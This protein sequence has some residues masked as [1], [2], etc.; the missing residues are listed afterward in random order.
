MAMQTDVFCGHIHQSGYIVQQ[1]GSRVKSI[2]VRGGASAAQFD[3]FSTLTAPVTATYAQS[4]SAVTVTK[5]AHGLVSGQVIGISYQ[6]GTGG[7]ATSGNYAVTVV[8]ADTFTVVSPN[9]NSVTAGAVCD[10]V[11]DGTWLMSLDL[12]AGDTYQNYLLLPGEGL[13][14]TKKVYALMSNLYSATVFYG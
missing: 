13:R 4:G 2:S 8:T 14:A 6:P 12:V 10:Y 11:V 9:P 7:A 3:L 5:V 1:V